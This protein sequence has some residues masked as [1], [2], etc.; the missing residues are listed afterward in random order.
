MTAGV[1]TYFYNWYLRQ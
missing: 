1:Q